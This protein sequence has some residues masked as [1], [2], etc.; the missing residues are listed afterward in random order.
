VVAVDGDVGGGGCCGRP[1]VDCGGVFLL[2]VYFL[3]R[4]QKPHG[5]EMDFFKVH[6]FSLPCLNTAQQSAFAVRATKSAR[7][8]A[9]AVQKI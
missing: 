2:F 1:A 9:F 6:V 5:K 7:Q 3:C 4:A 8:R